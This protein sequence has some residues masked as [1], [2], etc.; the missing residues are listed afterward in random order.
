[1]IDNG[2]YEI[3]QKTDYTQLQKAA[4]NKL[5]LSTANELKRLRDYLLLFLLGLAM[6][7]T[8]LLVDMNRYENSR[9][10]GDITSYLGGIGATVCTVIG[11]YVLIFSVIGL[12]KCLKRIKA[13]VNNYKK[14]LNRIMDE[15]I[16]SDNYI[17]VPDTDLNKY[18]NVFTLIIKTLK[19][20]KKIL[21]NTKI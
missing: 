14:D 9:V 21:E 19:N 2:E 15:L 12:V 5:F 7:L 18:N 8:F 20:R 6:G 10:K 1:M 11:A 17:D 16:Y 3:K 4:E 13:F